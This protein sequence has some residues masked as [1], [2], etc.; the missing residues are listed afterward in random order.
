[1][2]QPRLAYCDYIAHVIKGNL[3]VNDDERLLDEVG[4]IQY[5]MTP[6]GEFNSTTKTIDVLDVYGKQYRITVQ[7][8]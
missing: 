5:D 3:L 2:K 7:E 8:L 1:M 4:G 6:S